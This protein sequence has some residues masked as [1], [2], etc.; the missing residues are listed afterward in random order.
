M[1][2]RRTYSDFA[3]RIDLDAFEEAIGF[4]P[5]DN[6]RGE[7]I[8]YCIF[9][10]AHSHGDTTGKFAINREKRLWHCF[11][12]G[13]GDLLSLAMLHLE[14][15]YEE[16]TDWLY[17]FAG[18]DRRS[19]AKFADDL[20]EMLQD[21][22]ERRKTMPYFNPRVLDQFSG[23]LEYF[24]GR[25]INPFVADDAGLRYSDQARKAAP[26]KVLQ[27]GSRTK[28]DEDYIGPASIWPHYWQGKLV[29]WQCRWTDFDKEH[30]KTPKWLPKWTNT[31]DFPKA[32]TLYNYDYALKAKDRIVVCESLG[33]VLFLR[34]CGVPAVAYFGSKPAAE[35]LRLLRRFSQGVILAPDNDANMAGDKIL[36]TVE[37]LE[38]FIPVYIADKVE[39]KDGADLGDYWDTDDPYKNLMIH[40]E[41]RVRPADLSLDP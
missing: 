33:T 9:P 18:P 13:G 22:H 7:D 12:C 27:D 8:G 10:E 2:K 40:L 41:N 15:D 16:A 5:F 24:Y 14:C 1:A 21:V 3:D 26:V 37:Y 6:S 30:T 35:Q 4:E 36:G 34:S 29:G 25:G 31:T 32:T 17:A 39:G 20:L 38:R 19:D 23:S 28:N 11:V